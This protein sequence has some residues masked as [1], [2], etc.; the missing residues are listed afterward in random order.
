[1]TPRATLLASRGLERHLMAFS[2]FTPS[3]MIRS[4]QSGVAHRVDLL[5]KGPANFLLYL[6]RKVCPNKCNGRPGICANVHGIIPL[7]SQFWS[8]FRNQCGMWLDRSV[9][10]RSPPGS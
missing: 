3:P 2:R 9:G 6:L 1:M 5:E 7:Q 4:H 10:F 8:E